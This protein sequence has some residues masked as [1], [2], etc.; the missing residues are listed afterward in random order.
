MQAATIKA[1]V[2]IDAIKQEIASKVDA[3]RFASWFAPLCFEVVDNVLVLGTQN[4]FAA[5]FISTTYSNILNTVAANFGLGLRICIKKAS[6]AAPIKVQANDNNVQSYSAPSEMNDDKTVDF[7]SFVSCGDENAFVL[8]AC[9][10]MASGKATFSPLFIYGPAG[11]GKTLLANCIK[12]AS[13]GRTVM[14]SGS[15][16]VAEFARALHERT[17]FAFKDYCRNCDTFILD[18]VQ[19]LAGKRATCDEFLQLIN[20]LRNEGKNVVLVSSAA[21]SNLSGF[22]HHA[23]SLFASGLSADIVAPSREV[24]YKIFLRSGVSPKVAD[25]LAGR[26]LA[27]GHIISG[28][29]NKINTYAEFMGKTVDEDAIERLLADTLKKSKSPIVMVKSMCEKLGVTY[30]AVC[31]NGRCRALVLARQMMMSVLKSV[32]GLSL[33]EIGQYVGGRDHATVMYGLERIEK[34]KATDLILSAQLTEMI[35]EYK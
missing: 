3:A 30:E 33:A 28:I 22:D 25:M 18:D 27:D 8:S 23:Q 11:S 21:P 6:C 31:G 13:Q 1:N 20:D 24:R 16:F 35:D 32:S 19:V 29:L 34:L 4:Q 14:M 2:D 5:D 9:K 10:K 17:I 15:Q 7:D 12:N 26:V